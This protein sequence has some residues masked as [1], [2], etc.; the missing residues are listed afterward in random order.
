MHGGKR[1]HEPNLRDRFHPVP[2]PT[3]HA[4]SRIILSKIMSTHADMDVDEN[5]IDEGLYS[6]QL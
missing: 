6:R 3:C 2:I 1:V 4:V 5:Q